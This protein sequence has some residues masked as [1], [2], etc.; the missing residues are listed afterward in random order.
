MLFRQSAVCIEKYDGL[1]PPESI[2]LNFFPTW[3]QIHKL[4]IGYRNKPLITNLTEKKVGKVLEVE[5]NVQGAGNFVRARVKLYVR[6]P[7]ARFV[8]MSRAGQREIYQIK[9]E[10]M[11]RFC[12]ACGM[13]GHSHLECGT[14]EFDEEKLKWGDWLKAD[15]DTW[16]GRAAG[17]S[18]GGRTG[19]GGRDGPPR[20]GGRGG[21]PNP[22]R[23][24]MSGRGNENLTSWRHNA[25]IRHEGTEGELDDPGTSPTKKTDF[26]MND[27]HSSD[28]GAK[29]RLSLGYSNPV[30]EEQVEG[31]LP[32]ITEFEIPQ[33]NGET[34]DTEM[35][36]SKRTKKDG[37]DSPSL[38]SAGS[39]E[40]SVRSQ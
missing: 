18:R 33:A 37:A 30:F 3:I 39:R 1:S 29:R 6:K 27:R 20:G 36:R 5:T 2:D 13:I 25:I 28:S 9:F 35:D 10:K 32:M 34:F 7:L 38:G 21:D 24:N 15:W 26:D 12:A 22:G 17:A 8:S 14:G 19:R 23:G 16:H 31:T 40:E 4:P 11:P